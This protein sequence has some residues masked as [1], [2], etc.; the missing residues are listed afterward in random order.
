[1]EAN[2]LRIGNHLIAE[3]EDNILEVKK[4]YSL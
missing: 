2:E 1:M 4:Q 3:M